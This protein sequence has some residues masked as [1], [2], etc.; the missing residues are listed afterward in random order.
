M[1]KLYDMFTQAGKSVGF[2]WSDVFYC[3]S[4]IA[5]VFS[6]SVLFHKCFKLLHQSLLDQCRSYG[7][8]MTTD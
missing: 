5:S 4:V 3:I 8:E 1:V 7:N 6:A 2:G